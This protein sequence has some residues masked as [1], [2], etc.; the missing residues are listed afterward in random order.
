MLNSEETIGHFI[1][2]NQHTHCRYY[3]IL[4]IVCLIHDLRFQYFWFYVQSKNKIKTKTT[5]P[6][7]SR[8]NSVFQSRGKGKIWNTVGSTVQYDL[9]YGLS[10]TEYG[11]IT[12]EHWNIW[13]DIM[14]WPA[15]KCVSLTSQRK[16]RRFGIVLFLFY[17]LTLVSALFITVFRSTYFVLIYL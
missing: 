14:E 16:S 2:N 17:S 5:F 3:V 9:W 6:F 10:F 13:I 8:I 4:Y 1:A 7:K 15:P 12:I 11:Q